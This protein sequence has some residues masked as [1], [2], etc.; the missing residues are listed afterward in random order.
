VQ[1][2]AF[3]FDI[4]CSY[5]VVVSVSQALQE[6][7]SFLVEAYL[8]FLAGNKLSHTSI[9]EI[10]AQS[11]LLA[12]GAS[13][14]SLPLP[15]SSLPSSSNHRHYPDQTGRLFHYHIASKQ[16]AKATRMRICAVFS[17]ANRLCHRDNIEMHP[18]Q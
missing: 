18:D 6:L 16:R 10:K 9:K 1:R 2:G 7:I 5:N 8:L 4:H 14:P 15:P 17:G 11:T 3:K 12:P 13:F